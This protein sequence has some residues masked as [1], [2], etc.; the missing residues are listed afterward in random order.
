MTDAAQRLERLE[1][2]ARTV[3]QQAQTTLDEMVQRVT[4]SEPYQ[5]FVAMRTQVVD[6]VSAFIDNPKEH[7]V[8]AASSVKKTAKEV[9]HHYVRPAYKKVEHSVVEVAKYVDREAITPVI[10]AAKA[11]YDTAI[12]AKNA[13]V[14]YVKKPWAEKVADVKQWAGEKKEQLAKMLPSGGEKAPPILAKEEKKPAVAP[15]AA[16]QALSG[17]SD[18]ALALAKRAVEGLTPS[19]MAKTMSAASITTISAPMVPDISSA[20]GTFLGAP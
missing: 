14:A 5:R 2:R 20:I 7:L 13:T 12:E 4:T 10:H 8:A 11:A 6:T 9:V 16:R 15:S 19:A 18:K 3:W 17:L 1:A